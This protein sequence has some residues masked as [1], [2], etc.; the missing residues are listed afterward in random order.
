[1]FFWHHH[2]FV[3]NH[4]DFSFSSKLRY[5]FLDIVYFQRLK[6]LI[7]LFGAYAGTEFWKAD[8]F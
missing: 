3:S 5:G 1:V 4:G 7:K 6:E 8:T 2:G